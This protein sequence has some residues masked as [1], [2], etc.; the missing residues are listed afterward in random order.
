MASIISCSFGLPSLSSNK[1]LLFL[2]LNPLSLHE[3]AEKEMNLSTSAGSTPLNVEDEYN[4]NLRTQSYMDLYTMVHPYQNLGQ[5][6]NQNHKNENQ[7]Q[8]LNPS[9]NLSINL[10]PV[11][12]SF[13]K[14][15]PQF[16][17][18]PS[19]ETLR[20]F[21]L[22]S[23]LVEFFETTVHACAACSVI[24]ASL[25]MA[26]KHHRYIRLLLL[27]LSEVDA[28]QLHNRPGQAV[29]TELEKRVEKD[30]PLS[31][32]NLSL[33]HSAHSRYASFIIFVTCMHVWLYVPC[34][35]IPCD[36]AI[37]NGF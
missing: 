32:Q 15:L 12:S 1:T 25:D 34:L 21:Q 6:Q 37:V 11:P 4:A 35:R 5:E 22:S 16:V 24:L 31:S 7:D 2:S 19:Q 9:P 36:A 30:N 27:R 33:F 28:R 17:I 10:S 13:F 14:N 8:N 23:I 29:F 18:N 3:N 20:S 26:R